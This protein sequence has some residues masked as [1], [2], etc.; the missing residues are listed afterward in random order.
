M[1][2]TE[3]LT[4]DPSYGAIL[5]FLGRC[6][7]TLSDVS[8]LKDS[9]VETLKWLHHLHLAKCT[10]EH[11]QAQLPPTERQ[12]LV[13]LHKRRQPFKQADREWTT[14]SAAEQCHALL[15][16]LRN[17]A[18]QYPWLAER[19]VAG[20]LDDRPK[21]VSPKVPVKSELPRVTQGASSPEEHSEKT[22]PS[23]ATPVHASTP[24]SL[25]T[26]QE[27]RRQLFTTADGSI[28]RQRR[29]APEPTDPEQSERLVQHHRQIHDELTGDLVHMAQTLKG[30]SLLFGDLLSKDREVLQDAQEVISNNVDHMQKHGGRLT[31]YSRKSWSTTWMTWLIILVV[32]LTFI[33]VYFVVRLFPKSR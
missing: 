12:R 11:M 31:T 30:N 10:L 28:L 25:N 17:Q 5:Q 26:L 6:Q 15:R 7:L 32:C 13:R 33:M 14:L 16:N 8:T 23:S 24:D 9:P 2:T 21:A 19:D 22:F 18:S 3:A 20:I 29:Y 1:T 4:N 27:Q